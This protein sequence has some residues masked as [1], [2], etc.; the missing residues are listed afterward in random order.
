M[1]SD[2]AHV[3]EVIFLLEVRCGVRAY[4]DPHVPRRAAP[5]EFDNATGRESSSDEVVQLDLLIIW[6]LGSIK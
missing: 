3:T 1:L 6:H 5:S 2:I 4:F